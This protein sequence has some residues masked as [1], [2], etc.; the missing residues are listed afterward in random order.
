M[1]GRDGRLRAANARFEASMRSRMGEVR[2]VL[3]FEDRFLQNRIA[4]VLTC[5]EEE[6]PGV[7]SVGMHGEGGEAPLVVHIIPLRG[8]ARDVGGSDGVLLLIADPDNASLPGADLLRLLF[9]LTPAE[10]RIARLLAEGR[11]AEQIAAGSRTTVL[12]VR[13]QLKAVFGKTGT[14]RQTELVR[15][16]LGIRPPPA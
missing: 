7:A 11:T 12:T 1:V 9:D 14:T 6:S 5:S 10:A 4:T 2:G 13:S 8:K 15:L 3:Q 16:L